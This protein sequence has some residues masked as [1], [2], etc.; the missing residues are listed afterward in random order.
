MPDE[1][2]FLEL[3]DIY[4]GLVDKQDEIIRRLG[5]VVAKQSAD[6]EQYKTVYGFMDFHENENEEM[7]EVNKSL[8]EYQQMKGID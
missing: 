5:K 2:A 1:E 6:I 4:M 3:L 8:D 7:R